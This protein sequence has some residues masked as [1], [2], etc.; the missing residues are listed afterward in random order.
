MCCMRKY[1]CFSCFS[2][3]DFFSNRG[4]GSLHLPL[5]ADASSNKYE[6]SSFLLYFCPVLLVCSCLSFFHC[7]PAFVISN[8]SLFSLKYSSYCDHY[9]TLTIIAVL[10]L[11]YDYHYNIVII[12]ELSQI[13]HCCYYY[14]TVVITILLES[15]LLHHYYPHHVYFTTTALIQCR[16]IT[17]QIFPLFTHNNT[18]THRFVLYC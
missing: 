10:L 5:K 2:I 3:W 15:L 16:D 17:N 9:V 12:T 13:L 1:K 14:V 11:Y 8:S 4:E 18:N 7:A 6:N